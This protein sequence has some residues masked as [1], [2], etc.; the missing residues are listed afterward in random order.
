[1]AN[2]KKLGDFARDVEVFCND[3]RNPSATRGELL[4]VDAEDCSSLIGDVERFL[5]KMLDSFTG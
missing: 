4:V 5:K 1:M 2:D 3:Y